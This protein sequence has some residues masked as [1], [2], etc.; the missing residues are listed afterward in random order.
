MATP[1]IRVAWR[2]TKHKKAFKKITTYWHA[3]TD[4]FEKKKKRK[5]ERKKEKKGYDFIKLQ[6]NI[7]NEIGH[8]GSWDRKR[9]MDCMYSP[10]GSRDRKRDCLFRKRLRL[11]HLINHTLV[12]RLATESCETVFCVFVVMLGNRKT[13]LSA[14]TYTFFPNSLSIAVTLVTSLQE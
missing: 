5:K 4:V 9:E 11:W 2:K 13:F 6:W 3:P 14:W 12:F 10:G 7:L 8:S 1:S